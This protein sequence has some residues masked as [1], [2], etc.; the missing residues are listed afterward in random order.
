MNDKQNTKEGICMQEERG[1]PHAKPWFSVTSELCIQA[2]NQSTEADGAKAIRL[3]S[4]KSRET[5][6]QENSKLGVLLLSRQKPKQK[7][8]IP[9]LAHLEASL[10]VLH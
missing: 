4:L 2:G 5:E 8:F 6:A 9:G 10:C 7:L 1:L 3:R